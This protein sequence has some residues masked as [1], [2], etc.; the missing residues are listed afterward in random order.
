MATKKR[1]KTPSRATKRA[2]PGWE[3][4][5]VTRGLWRLMAP[6]KYQKNRKKQLCIAIGGPR[7][8]AVVE[9]LNEMGVEI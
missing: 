8:K 3:V 5:Q 9:A 7:L 6:L 1:S 2:R 4:V